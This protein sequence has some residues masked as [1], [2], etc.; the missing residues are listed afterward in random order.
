MFYEVKGVKQ[1]PGNLQRR[2]FQ[3]EDMD[4]VVW[5]ADDELVRFQ[6]S[7]DRYLAEKSIIW[8]KDT[9][10]HHHRIDDGENQPGHYKATPIVTGHLPLDFSQALQLFRK[11]IQDSES[12][13]FRS[14]LR[15]LENT[16]KD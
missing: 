7:Y 15:L 12:S 4:L 1:E 16:Q 14:V 5:F 11:N 3:A 10:F 2:W 13:L 9:G 8:S 6:L